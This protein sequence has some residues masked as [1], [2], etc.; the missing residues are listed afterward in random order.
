MFQAILGI[1]PSL[2][3]QSASRNLIKGEPTCNQSFSHILLKGDQMAGKGPKWPT[4][5]LFQLWSPVAWRV[6]K[7]YHHVWNTQTK[8]LCT[9]WT[10]KLSK[11][12]AHHQDNKESIVLKLPPLLSPQSRQCTEI[13]VPLSRCWHCLLSCHWHPPLHVVGVYCSF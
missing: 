13:G 5:E 6:C 8:A 7:I 1:P 2:H 4:Q 11:W 10:P 9:K 3:D 12:F